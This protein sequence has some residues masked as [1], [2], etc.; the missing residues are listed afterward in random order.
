[1]AEKIRV[2][3]VDDESILLDL[4]KLYLER[5]GDFTVTTVPSAPEVI[6]LLE[7]ERFD[8]I[9]SDY[10]MPE[11][12]G[13]GF[14]KDVRAR[15]DKTPFIIFT[16]KGREE[17]VIQALNCG[18]DFYIQKGGESTSQF[19]ELAHKILRAVEHQSVEKS[20]V[21]SQ[22]QLAEAMDLAHLVTWEYDVASGIF[23]F[24]DRFYALYGTTAER[25]GGYQMPAEVYA[26]EFVHPD[27]VSVVWDET[28][29]AMTATDPDYTR[30]IEHRIIRRDG[31]VRH[32]IVRIVI[33][34]DADGRTVK[35]HGANQDI[36]DRKRMEEALRKSTEQYRAVI[37]D[38]TEFIC[39]FTPNGTLTFVND[40]Y[41]RYFSLDR[42]RCLGNAYTVKLLPED[43]RRMK[44]H[45]AALT[46]QNPV[47][48]IE[49][50]IIM[51]S[52]EVRW[53]RWNDRA[54]FDRNGTVIEYQSV[55][56][57]ITGIKNTE[58]ALIEREA[59]YRTIFE[60]T[61][62]ASIIVEEDTTISLANAEFANLCGYPREEIEGKRCWTEFV[63]KED[64]QRMLAQHYSRRKDRKKAER[65]Y[66]FRF[67]RKNGEI[68]TIYLSID[69]IPGTQKSIASLLDITERKRAENVVRVAQEKYTKAFLSAPDAITIS[70][71]DSGRFIEVNDAAM[72]LFGYPR[73]ELLGKSA[74]ELGIW[75]K[76]EDRDRFIDQIRKHGKVS[77]FEVLERRKSGELYYALV[78]AD[79]ISIGNATY[80]IAML[81]DM[82]E[83]KRMEESLKEREEQYRT[84]VTSVH[85]AIILQDKNGQI[86][87]WN[88][89]AERLFGVTAGDV[90]GHT[91]TSRKWKTIREDGT[92]FPDSEHPSMHTLATG[93]ACRNVVMGITSAEGRFSWVNIN[94][95][96]LFRQENAKPDA[97]VISLLDITEQGQAVDAL[98]QSEEKLRSLF[99][100]LPVGVSILDKNRHIVNLNPALEQI[101]SF[102]RDELMRGDHRHRRYL[103]GDGTPMSPE[104]YASSRAIAEKT[105]VSGVETGVVKE[106]GS[107][108]WTSV[109]AAPLEGD[110]L[111]AVIVTTD[112]TGRKRAETA[113][114]ESEKRYRS[115]FEGVPLGLYRTTPSGQIL[116]INPA[117]VRVLGYPDRESLLA[118]S[119]SA[120]YKNPGDRNQWLALIER[121]GI[122]HDF[123]VQF[124]TY[125]GTIIWVR[126]T[127]EAVRDDS[128]QVLYYDGYVEDITGRKQ[129]EAALRESEERY[130]L[131]A[132]NTS[133]T[134]WMMDLDGT[135]IYH[136]PAVEKL[137]GYTPEEAN[138]IPLDQ[139]FTPASLSYIREIFSEEGNKPVS[140]RWG[141]RIIE[142]E[143]LKKDG[144][145]IWTD[146]SVRAVRDAKGNVTHLQGSTRDI[147][148]RKRAE[149][150]LAKLNER[151]LMFGPDPLANI[152]LLVALCGELMDATCALY[153]CMQGDMLC[154]LGQWHT[155]PGYKATDQP[156][157]HIC[158]D[159][160]TTADSRCVV[161][162]NLQDTSYALTD[163]NV[164][165][166][167]LKTYM[168]KAVKFGGAHIGSLC[169]VFQRDVIPDD[170][171]TYLMEL[172]AS[173]IGV[174]EDRKRTFEALRESEKRS[175]SLLEN[176]PELI[177]VHRNGNVLF[178]NP[179]ALKSLGY[180]PHEAL[181]RQVTD[182]VAP[183]FHERVIAAVRQRIRGT[184]VEPYEID[185]IARD[186]NRRTMVVNGSTIEFDGAPASLILLTDITGRK[187]VEEELKRSE[188]RLR[189]VVEDQTE[190][191]C[192]FTPD[193]RL[194][195][196]NDAYVRYFG[197][198][199]NQCLAHPHLV[200]LTPED[201]RLM[202]HH[203]DSLTPQNPVASIEHRIIMPSGE[204][205]WQRWSDRAIFGE[206]GTVIE[207]QSVG[208]DITDQKRAELALRQ[209]NKQLHLLSS[210]TR[211]DIRNQV[212]A[213]RG[214]IELSR[215]MVQDKETLAR[216][217]ESA[218]LA[219]KT[220]EEQISFTKDYQ[221][222]G[223]EVPAWQNVNHCIRNT[224]AALPMRAVHVEPDPD[225]PEVYADPL[226]ERVFY[227]LFDNALRYGGDQMSTIR[228]SSQ[229]SEWGLIIVC[230][231]N[232]VGIL[233]KDKK[234][235]FRK[236]FG[237]HTGLG[238]FLSREILA[239][240][241]IT[242]AET[243]MPGK[244]ARFEITVPKGLYRFTG[245]GNDTPK[246]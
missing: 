33:T 203:L 215:E 235:L 3:Y 122:V 157:G 27:E 21:K 161:I 170:N 167:D 146:V 158:H 213:L 175:R 229:E 181:N 194:T 112:I 69:V 232:G 145:T 135:F 233:D 91:A 153:N 65:N 138:R 10:Q 117:L 131:L 116:D 81:H 242:I 231:D 71:L 193:G 164:R 172:I 84:L 13:I 119:V 37:E 176:V 67:V 7:K 208:R 85:E 125:D 105:V 68:R 234:K 14:L 147:T 142:L 226:F 16:G 187:K 151:F 38:Q 86:L 239:I 34:K 217:L 214:Y 40:A 174:E 165:Q 50:R 8:A 160:I 183:E 60:N 144:F 218:D 223:A 87:T 9:V 184:P 101:L 196:V 41:C 17:V 115:L 96:P 39:R 143:L 82:T 42:V 134:I 1:M 130:R 192:R 19:A 95:T 51:P 29:N 32:I 200:V 190:F 163:P 108:I 236:G 177:L 4:G 121:E 221:E 47:A 72:K 58:K 216:F 156:R 220:I 55:G 49:H 30:Q 225:D 169:V 57:D 185:V 195:F 191:I 45:L 211:H 166:Y 43:A 206:N 56:S 23:T 36:T 179:A 162:R 2:L 18:A 199:K 189:A 114:R 64:L 74:L 70:E 100:I 133:D 219:A 92:E 97:V 107:V 207:Y 148:K 44:Q 159:V 53:Q 79:T 136:S 129:A 103:R 205:R 224:M 128:G 54:I 109:S 241:G 76:Q 113:L 83:R 5:S 89:A 25:E 75:Q 209:A 77:Q 52:G 94:T 22:I 139:S 62:T 12:D 171:D 118:V 245:T 132:E 202:K 73:E 6:R 61:G 15:G 66:E 141:D 149:E 178:T 197:L 102:S 59:Y 123:E 78:N 120:L 222:M 152:N 238:L 26:R 246:K 150:R 182:F 137:C 227:N 237:R 124:R 204:V 154:S 48:A 243:G 173:A 240:S 228:I 111:S 186:G 127:G 35:T 198:D 126:D 180:Q 28:H 155:P 110:E 140:E 99:Q 11:Q 98:R 244:G 188:A 93:E 212:L 106:D 46:P 104:E 24:N 230:E 168:G 31:E 90:L 210:I 20:L 63:V 80:L 201:A 88:N